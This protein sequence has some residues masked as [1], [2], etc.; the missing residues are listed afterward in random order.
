MSKRNIILVGP[1]NTGKTTLFNQLT[2][3]NVKTVNY[4][5]STID[6]NMGTYIKNNDI[7]IIDTPGLYSLK[8]KSDDEYITVSALESIQKITHSKSKNPDLIISIIDINQ[9]SRHL[10]H[11]TQIIKQGY[12]VIIIINN[13]VM[14]D[15]HNNGDTI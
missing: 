5:G 6:L 4:P 13:H 10:I 11:V 9:A 1:P 12:P 8:P 15:D 3:K 7:A 14:H 2:G